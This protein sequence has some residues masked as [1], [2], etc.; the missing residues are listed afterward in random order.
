MPVLAIGAAEGLG[1]GVVNTMKLVADD[2]QSMIIPGSGH[3]VAEQG[4]EHL[5]AALTAFLAPYREAAAA[6]VARRAVIT[7]NTGPAGMTFEVAARGFQANEQVVTWLNTPTNV[8]GLRLSGA[9]SATGNIQLQFD[10]TGLAPG[11]YGLVL[12]GRGSGREY[13]LPFGLTG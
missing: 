6:N 11:Y 8:Q 5:L 10:S 1:E 2:L 4:P 7:P 9:A 3:W 12:H 13:L